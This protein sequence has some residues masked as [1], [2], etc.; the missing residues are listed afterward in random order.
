MRV[1]AR[2]HRWPVPGTLPWYRQRMREACRAWRRERRECCSLT[3]P[4]GLA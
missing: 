1:I 4:A 2:S 3:R